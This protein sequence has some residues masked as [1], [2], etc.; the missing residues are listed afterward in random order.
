MPEKWK[1]SEYKRDKMA[2]V[3]PIGTKVL[4]RP[5]LGKSEVR[6]AE[7]RSAPWVLGHGAVVVAITGQAGGVSVDHLTIV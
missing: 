3:M 1:S 5:V 4:Y 2:E 7:I 6:T